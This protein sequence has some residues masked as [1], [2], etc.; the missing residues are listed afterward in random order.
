[1]NMQLRICLYRPGEMLAV[2]ENRTKCVGG[3]Q[4]S[5]A[6]CVDLQAVGASS[7]VL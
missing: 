7:R 1:M 6:V 4:G 3:W 2:T 5:C